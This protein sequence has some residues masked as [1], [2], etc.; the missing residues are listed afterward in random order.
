MKLTEGLTQIQT[1]NK[2]QEDP[3]MADPE[4][5][6]VLY[7]RMEIHG[8]PMDVL[9]IPFDENYIE[10]NCTPAGAYSS[11]TNK[12]MVELGSIVSSTALNSHDEWKIYK[13]R[14]NDERR[15]FTPAMEAMITT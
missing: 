7:A 3:Y 9:L 14:P 6:Y 15:I 4:W 13:W 5:Q 10:V 8:P 2:Q 11:H 12:H 1:M